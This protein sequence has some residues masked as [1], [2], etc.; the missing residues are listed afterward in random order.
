MGLPT[1]R[2]T[3]YAIGSQIK[4]ADLNAIQDVE[5]DHETRIVDH[6]TR[7]DDIEAG[8]HGNLTLII[9]AGAAE[10]D[11]TFVPST[12]AVGSLWLSAGG[13]LHLAYPIVL[14]GSE[15]IKEVKAHI[16]DESG[17]AVTMK[18]FKST[19]TGGNTQVGSTQTSSSAGTDQTLSL[20]G[21]T[22]TIDSNEFFHIL[23]TSAASGVAQ[24][25]YAC[26]VL[27]DRVA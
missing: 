5:I 15:R 17:L 12:G 14:T 4:S 25:S 2:N 8:R 22:E 9:P 27:F 21:L 1:S 10:G 3:T 20:T 26:E 11:W 24:R 23:I 18:L 13:T 16:K 6:E 7:I 19:K